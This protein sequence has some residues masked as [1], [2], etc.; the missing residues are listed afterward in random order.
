MRR[1]LA[2]MAVLIAVP[3]FAA[4]TTTKFVLAPTTWTD[5]GVGPLTISAT[6]SAVFAIGDTTPAIPANEGGLIP[7]DDSIALNTNSHVWAMPKNATI[8][9]SVFTAPAVF[10]GGSA[11]VVSSV[12]SAS[13]AA[14]NGM[15]LSNGGL[16]V[17]P[18]VQPAARTIRNTTSKSSGKLYA[19]FAVTGMPGSGSFIAGT[20]SASMNI[21]SY[22]GNSSYSAGAQYGIANYTSAGFTDHFGYGIGAASGD[23][24][25]IAVDFGTGSIWFSLNNAWYGSANPATGASPNITFVPATVGPLFLGLSF[26][27]SG[28]GLWTLQPT[29]A[30]QKYAAPSGF[31]AW[32]SGGATGCSQATAYL[33]RATGE[34]AHPADL[35]NLICGLVSDGVWSKL[36]ALYLFAQQTQTD[37][38]LNLVSTSYGPL[39]A[40]T[41]PPFTAYQGFGGFIAGTNTFQTGLTIPAAHYTQNSASFGA[42]LPQPAGSASSVMGNGIS[43]GSSHFYPLF[44]DGNTY[45]RLNAASTPGV[46]WPPSPWVGY[47]AGDRI[48]ATLVD[49]YFNGASRGEVTSASETPIP[50]P[51]LIGGQYL[52][53]PY[54]LSATH[55]GASLGAAGQAALYNR[56]R[57]YMTAVGNT[58][59]AKPGP[60]PPDV[61]NPTKP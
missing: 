55:I 52:A 6:G 4:T 39:T 53:T 17:D 54:V 5:L 49:Y 32:D 18:A 35:I 51:F 9:A 15:T 47:Y 46:L 10:G 2:I 21:G 37:A 14:A 34:T 38:L 43:T 26:N 25:G 16:T 42:W 61:I 45:A 13:D 48:S 7:S 36:D 60:K 40:P 24:L 30:S 11:P 58:S 28:N 1:W 59:L 19:E 20:G 8:G 23:V 50:D 33:A 12:W 31:T 29:A 27:A 22:L 41:I 57:T 56:L 3:A 44:T